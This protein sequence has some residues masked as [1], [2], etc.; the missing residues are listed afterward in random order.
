M[1]Q[2]NSSVNKE[3]N[4]FSLREDDKAFVC[5]ACAKE[6]DAFSFDEFGV[7]KHWAANGWMCSPC[8][9]DYLYHSNLQQDTDGNK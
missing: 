8:Y 5:K 7:D 4:M 3:T 9:D 2:N 6:Y 1:N